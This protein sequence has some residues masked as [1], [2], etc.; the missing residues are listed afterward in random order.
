MTRSRCQRPLNRPCLIYL[1]YNKVTILLHNVHVN[2]DRRTSEGWKNTFFNCGRRMMCPARNHP[3]MAG[4]ESL[5]C[6]Y[7]GSS[8]PSS[9]P[10]VARA[11]HAARDGV[12]QAWAVVS[13]RGTGQG[14]RTFGAGTEWRPC[15]PPPPH[16]APYGWANGGC[17]SMWRGARG[18]GDGGGHPSAGL[19]ISRTWHA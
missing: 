12:S 14:P 10:T 13:R 11:G 18:D 4:G 16:I 8:G 1:V 7:A 9:V 2:Y 5:P 15:I 17:S 6:M 3:V 19:W